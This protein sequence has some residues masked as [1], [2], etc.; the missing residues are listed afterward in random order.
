MVSVIAPVS[1]CSRSIS[2]INGQLARLKAFCTY[3]MP[4]SQLEVPKWVCGPGWFF[5]HGR[6]G[7]EDHVF[8]AASCEE[9]IR[10]FAGF[11]SH[12]LELPCSPPFFGPHPRG[13]LKFMLICNARKSPAR[14]EPN[15]EG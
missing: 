13:S 8:V 6:S 4:T 9:A 7:K 14:E 2:D 12:R 5:G 3:G 10:F 15:G 1:Y 11:G